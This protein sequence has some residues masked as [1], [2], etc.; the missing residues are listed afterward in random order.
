MRALTLVSCLVAVVLF[1]AGLAMAGQPS[2]GPTAN[3]NGWRPFPPD[4]AW[5]TDVSGQAVDALSDLIIASIGSATGLH[6]D[7]GSGGGIPYNVVSGSQRKV[8]VTLSDYSESDG[9]MLPI[10]PNALI[11]GGGNGGPGDSHVLII[12]RDTYTIYEIYAVTTERQDSGRRWTTDCCSIFNA[13]GSNVIRP[14]YWTSSDAAGLSVFAGLVKYEDLYPG[15]LKHAVRFTAVNT[16]RAFL[17]PATHYASSKTSTMYIPMGA[18]VRLKASFNTATYQ[19]GT[20]VLLDG[21]KKYGLIMSD[22]G[23]NWFL[24]GTPD[25]RWDDSLLHAIIGCTGGNFEL[26]QMVGL[27][28]G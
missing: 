10:P 19:G 9:M 1:G 18:R 14:R 24:T 21:L 12:D 2:L 28:T 20:K 16:R 25:G 13:A 27:V 23:S 3:L 5:N 6:P 4:N 17:P 15:P 22:N 7:F 8:K 11:E 26:V